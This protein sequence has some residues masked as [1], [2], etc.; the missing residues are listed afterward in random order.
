MFYTNSIMKIAIDID[1]TLFDC[2]KSLIY[3]V[4]NSL[5]KIIPKRHKDFKYLTKEDAKNIP[6]KFRNLF[7]KMGDPEKYEEVDG[8]VD[9]IKKFAS[10]GHQ[11]AFLSSR[12]NMR[13]M[14]QVIISWLQ[15]HDLPNDFVV[16]NCSDK[17]GFCLEHGI[18]VL[19]DDGLKNCV[20]TNSL[21]I[22]TIHLN[23]S[24]KFSKENAG[25]KNP[26]KFYVANGWKEVENQIRNIE[27]S[28]NNKDLEELEEIQQMGM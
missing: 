4:A 5:E 7:G 26:D 20:S 8:S 15:K 14:N 17:A 28:Q 16:V 13:I 2:K 6:I 12:P 22:S 10:E 23:P 18:D 21:G 3:Q 9:I 19:I 27:K 24:K 25:V 11:I 1:K